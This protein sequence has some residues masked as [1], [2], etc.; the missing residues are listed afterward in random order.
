MKQIVIT[1]YGDPDVLKIQERK[2]P[3]PSAGEVLIKV[4]AIGV[5]FADILARKGLYPD[6]PKPPCVVG[7]EVSG[8]IESTGPDVD[9]SIVGPSV[10]ALTRFNG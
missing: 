4:K 2:D 6:A 5:D 1:K 3:Q 7:Y 9:A 8:T 10:V